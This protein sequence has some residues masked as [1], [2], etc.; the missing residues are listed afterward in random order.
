MICTPSDIFF[1]ELIHEN[2]STD[3]RLA[4]KCKETFGLGAT[5]TVFSLVFLH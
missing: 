1:L 3:P 4:A 5:D 2:S